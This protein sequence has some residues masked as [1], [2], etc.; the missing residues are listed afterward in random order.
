MLA[1]A[2]AWRLPGRR[3]DLIDSIYSDPSAVAGASVL[4]QTLEVDEAGEPVL[5]RMTYVDEETCIGCKNCAL[6]A[7][8]TFVM[9]DDFAGNPREFFFERLHTWRRPPRPPRPLWRGPSRPPRPR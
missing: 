6:V 9:N 7:R 1:A 2:L 5:A 8:N 3:D 4:P